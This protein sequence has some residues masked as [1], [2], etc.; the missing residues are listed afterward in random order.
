MGV[1]A[2]I[3]EIILFAGDYVPKGW[4]PC[5]GRTVIKDQFNPLFSVIGTKFGGDGNTTFRVP[6]LR[7]RVPIGTGSEGIPTKRNLGDTGGAEQ[8]TLMTDMMPHHVHSAVVAVNGDVK[9]KLLGVKDVG[10]MD[11]PQGCFIAGSAGTFARSGETVELN[12]GSIE[13]NTRALT[14]QVGING[15]GASRPHDNMPPFTVLNYII[16]YEGSYPSRS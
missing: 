6:D 11:S 15:A 14:V 13:V 10:K 1:D 8:V 5:D 7:G 4:L 3:G 9:A 12:G 16:A 2:Y